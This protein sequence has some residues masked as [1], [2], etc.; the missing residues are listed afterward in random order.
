MAWNDA[1][2]CHQFR[3]RLTDPLK[4][5]LARVGVPATLQALIA[6]TI[7]ID[8]RLRERRAERASGSLRPGWMRSLGYPPT[9][10]PSLL[11]IPCLPLLLSPLSLC[12]W[13]C[14]DLH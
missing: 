13:D 1:T 3:L 6:L 8:R 12:S 14:C 4:N 5:E 7:Q 9:E 11:R 10:A 2:L